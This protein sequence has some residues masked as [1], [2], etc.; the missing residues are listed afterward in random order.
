MSDGTQASA[1]T[2][3]DLDFSQASALVDPYPLLSEA[4]NLEHLETEAVG[5][6]Q[7]AWSPTVGFSNLD[8]TRLPMVV[9]K[10]S[11]MISRV[12]RSASAAMVE[13]APFHIVHA[14]CR[15]DSY[16]AMLLSGS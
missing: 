10:G 2:A 7:P 16:R 1:P 3:A 6:E 8:S 13:I 12:F 11:T 5:Q 15:H 9:P 14:D 4:P